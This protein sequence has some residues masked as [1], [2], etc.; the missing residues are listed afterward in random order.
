[1]L[2]G[3]ASGT[4]QV[5]YPLHSDVGPGPMTLTGDHPT[6]PASDSEPA[7]TSPP[8][9]VGT[10]AVVVLG[11]TAG[12]IYRQG[13]FY[14]LDA[15]GLVLVAVPLVLVGLVRNRDRYAATVVVATGGLALWW[16][17]RSSMERSPVAFLPL[18]ASML[19]FV[20]AFLIVRD[21]GGAERS[22]VSMAVVGLGAIVGAAGLAGLLLRAHPLARSVGGIWRLATTLTYPAGAAVLFVVALLV[23][24]SL[25]LGTPLAR[26]AVCLC[27]AGLIGTQSH[28][29]LVAVACAIPFL[30]WRRWPEAAWPL[31]TGS[32]AGLVVVVTS[33]GPRPT[34]LPC[35]LVAASVGASMIGGR[36]PRSGVRQQLAVG[37]VVVAA[38]L[39][40]FSMVHPPVSGGTGQP[41]DQSQTLAWSASY[42]A[43][44]SSVLTGVGPP[45]IQSNGDSV[46]SY[47]GLGPDVYLTVLADGGVIG[48][49]LLV[50]T[51]AAVILAIRR[52]D[53][54][55]SC[56][57]AGLVAFAVAGAVDLDWQLPA[58]ALVG[59]CVAGLASMPA[60]S[61]PETTHHSRIPGG[62]RAVVAWVAVV[63][64]VMAVQLAVGADQTAGGAARARVTPPPPSATPKSPAQIILRGPEDATDPFMLKTGGRYYLYTSE[65]TTFGRAGGPGSG[66]RR[67]MCSPTYPGGPRAG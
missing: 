39:T 67:S 21:L 16:L 51:G 1:M 15:F 43:W 17:V 8:A 36:S 52:R 61:S 29:D 46:D 3:P 23:A 18:G 50:G 6:A 49:L 34:W 55:S 64:V 63:V 14:P 26:A 7:T 42:E 33:T 53:L 11:L 4:D 40:V 22:R 65:G 37:G 35:A 19:G 32:V 48:A 13:A 24:L 27:L 41:A 28:W 38:G 60:R 10:L 5:E 44:H 56:A 9:G 12:A 66:G 20:A 25:D 59:G 2:P 54:L 45:R 31:L 47:P 30:P 62:G 58:L 57:T